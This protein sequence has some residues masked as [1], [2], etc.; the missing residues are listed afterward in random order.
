MSHRHDRF[1]RLFSGGITYANSGELSSGNVNIGPATAFGAVSSVTGSGQIPGMNG[2]SATVTFNVN[3]FAGLAVSSVTG[4][5]Q[6]PGMNGGSATVTFNVNAFAGLPVYL[7]T[8]AVTDPG[9]GM[10]ANTMVLFGKINKAG[11]TVSST[12]SWI[13][14]TTFPWVGYTLRWTVQN[15]A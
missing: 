3:A 4:S 10:S 9:A 2:G 14:T 8:I 15:N 7:G 6:I 13:K 5:G 1:H 11:N 12:N